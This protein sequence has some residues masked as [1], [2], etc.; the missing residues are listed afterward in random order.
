MQI[1]IHHREGSFSDRWIEYCNREQIPYKFVNCYRSDIIEQVADCDILLWH[2][3]HTIHKDV[4]AAKSIIFALEQ[5]GKKVFPDFNTCWHFDNKVAQKYL[6]EAIGAPLVP[7]YVFYDKAQALEWVSNTSFP[8]VFKLK[9]GA[10]SAN[11]KLVKTRKD[12]IKLVN[13]AF[14]RGFSQFDRLGHLRERFNKF[15]NGKDSF[16]GVCK[17]IGRLVIPTNYAK[18]QGREKGYVYFQDF[19]PNNKFDI[20]VIVIDNRAFAIKRFTRKNDFRASGSGNI[21]YNNEGIDI[22]CVMIA[23]ETSQMLKAQCLAYDFVFDE[24]SRPLIVEISYGF[25]QNAYLKCPGYWDANIQWN[26]EQIDPEAW[27]LE[28]MLETASTK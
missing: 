27:I 2:H 1:A 11:V 4:L 9:E 5:S 7:S 6:L 14:G 15:K 10:G 26:A 8:K 13:K 3:S 28:T 25:S 21:V 18:M 17:G 23:F 12:A 16:F 22:R 20:R 24:K 19:I